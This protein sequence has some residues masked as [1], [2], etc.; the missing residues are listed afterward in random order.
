MAFFSLAI[1]LLT[2]LTR[3]NALASAQAPLQRSIFFIIT[4]YIWL[5]G[6]AE[7]LR[8]FMAW[9]FVLTSMLQ[10][11]IICSYDDRKHLLIMNVLSWVALAIMIYL[12]LSLYI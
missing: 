12:E 10:T 1:F 11:L 4:L 8:L 6:H 9:G 7:N 5:S 3:I 2:H